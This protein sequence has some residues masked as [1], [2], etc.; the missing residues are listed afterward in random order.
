MY[1]DQINI[2]SRI[3]LADAEAYLR[4]NVPLPVELEHRVRDAVLIRSL[5][6]CALGLDVLVLLLED[7]VREERVLLEVLR[8]EI[9]R[10]T[11]VR[12]VLGTTAR[13]NSMVK[14]LNSWGSRTSQRSSK[15]ANAIWS[16]LCWQ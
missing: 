5:V 11:V 1:A 15:Y 14:A 6:F 2:R 8:R 12:R 9:T 7:T 3:T 13:T 4:D 16:R 10:S